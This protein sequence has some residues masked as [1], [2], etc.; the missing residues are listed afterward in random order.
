VILIETNT[1]NISRNLCEQDYSQKYAPISFTG[2]SLIYRKPTQ[3]LQEI[4]FYYK[5][6]QKRHPEP[7]ACHSPKG[8]P[9]RGG[10]SG[11][12]NL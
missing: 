6:S 11:A 9:L 4:S 8:T 5:L 1:N 3:G 7:F 12:K 2:D 10:V